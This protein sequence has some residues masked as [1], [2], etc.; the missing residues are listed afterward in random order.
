[1][2]H[3]LDPYESP[4]GEAILCHVCRHDTEEDDLG[5]DCCQNDDCQ[6]FIAVCAVCHANGDD[7]TILGGHCFRCAVE[8][9]EVA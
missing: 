7:Y 3:I 4:F 2:N 1:M 8:Y 5:R 9:G 6:L